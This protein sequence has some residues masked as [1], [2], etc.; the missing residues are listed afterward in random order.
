MPNWHSSY[1]ENNYGDFFYSLIRIYRPEKVVEL[2]T[3]TGYSAYHIARAL[4]DNGKGSID[5]YDLWE[6]YLDNY[7][8]DFITKSKTEQNLK[9]FKNLVTLNSSDALGVEQKYNKIDI[10]H[11][12]LN[13]DGEILEKIIPVWIDKVQQLIII[14]GGSIERDQAA[15]ATDFKKL[16]I[17]KWLKDL[18]NKKAE[19]L[20]SA[21]PD[22]DN[23]IEQFV[24]V[25]GK[26][27]YKEKP[28]EPWLKKFSR[29][30]GDLE[31]FT[32]EPFPSVTIIR[33]V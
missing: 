21:I 32:I 28:I 12:D 33:K 1:E 19:S 10:L 9:Q 3:L 27:Q 30:R 24:V 8:L 18:N 16:P 4:K 14:E 20:K 22:L 23:Q 2:G 31:Y 17:N 26:K 6:S 25:S 11:V 7:G 5:C 13:N 15:A 29:Q